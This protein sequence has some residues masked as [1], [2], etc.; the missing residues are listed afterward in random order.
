MV[1]Y[2]D[3]SNIREKSV[4]FGSWF[5][6]EFIMEGKPRQWGLKAVGHITFAVRQQREMD[7]CYCPVLFLH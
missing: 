2:S 3:K 7:E 1:K 6:E 5:K 4:Y